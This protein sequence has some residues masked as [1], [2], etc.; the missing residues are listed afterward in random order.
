MERPSYEVL[1]HTADLRLAF[2]GA[3]LPELFRN[4]AYGMTAEMLD[5][6][7]PGPT[8]GPL[9]VRVRRQHPDLHLRAWLAELLYILEAE[10]LLTTCWD[11]RFDRRGTLVAKVRGVPVAEVV[12][13]LKTEIKA[14]T[15]HGLRVEETSDGLRAEVIFDL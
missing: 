1:E 9:S 13:R 2:Y 10:H 4:A 15:Y 11:V 12:G 3:D 14:V 5:G 7:L 8:M 6:D